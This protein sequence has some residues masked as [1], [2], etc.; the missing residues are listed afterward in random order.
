[1]WIVAADRS[2]SL[3]PVRIA[4]Y[5]DDGAVIAEGLAAGERIVSAGVHKLAAGE[6]VRIVG[7]SNA[8]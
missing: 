5:R 2:L 4:A 6:K 8:K 7:S 3:R 1:V